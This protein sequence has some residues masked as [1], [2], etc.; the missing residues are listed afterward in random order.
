VFQG[1]AAI[2]P[3]EPLGWASGDLIN[4]LDN[5]NWRFTVSHGVERARREA[6]ER[7]EAEIVEGRSHA[8]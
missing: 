3:S 5:G 1:R 7:Q 2:S 4:V 8:G 6:Q